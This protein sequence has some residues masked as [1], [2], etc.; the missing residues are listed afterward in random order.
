MDAN[1]FVTRFKLSPLNTPKSR[2]RY[3]AKTKEAAVLVPL[4]ES[5]DKEQSSLKVLLTKRAEHLKH[6]PGQISFPGG[7]IEQSDE[8][9]VDAALRESYEE[10]GLSPER[11]KIIG[12]LKPYHT[13][14]GY[15]VTPIVALV[16]GSGDYTLDANEVAEVFE[17]PLNHFLNP[18]NRHT[19][20]TFYRGKSHH[21]HFMPYKQYN[22]W[23]A[24][25][26]MM[27]DLICH[28]Q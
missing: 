27:E 25:A 26:A 15:L 23:G 24:T 5:D 21:V 22:I 10:I 6:H 1:T 19:V 3:P 17:V 4:V 14:T 11:V 16:K 7:K 13:I 20:E 9:A 2:Y 28:I 12:Q 8:S 18:D